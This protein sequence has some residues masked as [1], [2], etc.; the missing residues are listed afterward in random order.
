MSWYHR[1]GACGPAG[2]RLCSGLLAEQWLPPYSPGACCLTPQAARA[3]GPE[4]GVRRLA[5]AAGAY[6]G[7]QGVL[8]AAHR[9]R[10]SR[11]ATVLVADLGTPWLDRAHGL[12]AR[13]TRGRCG[14]GRWGSVIQRRHI[15]TT[16]TT[17]TT[18]TT[19]AA[20]VM[21]PMRDLGKVAPCEL[22]R[23][24]ACLLLSFCCCKVCSRAL[25]VAFRALILSQM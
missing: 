19:T 3:G 23:V 4:R 7:R 18:M 12:L 13:L 17:T 11:G 20:T 10:G 6:P 1:Y 2:V 16:T 24:T 15:L 5:A 21:G 9:V 8:Y 14:G 22:M 25:S